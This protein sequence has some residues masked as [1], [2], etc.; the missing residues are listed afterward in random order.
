M[1]G[2]ILKQSSLLLVNRLLLYVF[3]RTLTSTSCIAASRCCKPTLASRR[4]LTFGPA[5]E[6]APS[7]GER[8]P[9]DQKASARQHRD[10]PPARRCCRCR[11]AAP[12]GPPAGFHAG[13][14]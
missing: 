13:P 10:G 1:S 2:N 11:P 7:Q 6:K 9:N 3:Q 14:G 8:G 5:R 12:C 4:P